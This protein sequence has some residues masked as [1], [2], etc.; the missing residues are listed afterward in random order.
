MLLSRTSR[1]RRGIYMR[2]LVVGST[3]VLGRNVVP[4]LLER[5]HTVRA[6]YRS[7]EQAQ[8]LAEMGAETAQGD[9]LDAGSLPE[10]ARECDVALHIATAVPRTGR[11][12]YTL[13][14][15]IRREG[16]RNLLSAC[17]Q[18]GVRRYVQQ[19]ITLVYG[20]SG[21]TLVDESEPVRPP[22]SSQS[23]ADM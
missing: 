7:P 2:V 5:G 21:P 4:R 6:L 18:N 17:V 11:G 13:N 10:A 19:S 16:T 12:D 1:G 3:G 14:D 20:E 8:F 15:R 9:I 23:A 22:A